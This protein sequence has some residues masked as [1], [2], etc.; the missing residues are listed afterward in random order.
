MKKSVFIILLITNISYL[1]AQNKF[2]INVGYTKN[3]SLLLDND[4]YPGM[5]LKDIRK[6]EREFEK[7]RP[8]HIRSPLHCIIVNFGMRSNNFE[9]G[10]YYGIGRTRI[11]DYGQ[12]VELETGKKV[13]APNNYYGG[14]GIGPEIQTFGIYSNFYVSALVNNEIFKRWINFY[15][16]AKVGG[17]Y[18]TKVDYSQTI[19]RFTMYDEL[20]AVHV[21]GEVPELK[22]Y[23]VSNIRSSP[24]GFGFNCYAGTGV[25]IFPFKKF[26]IFGEMGYDYFP[27]D[28]KVYMSKMA[29]RLGASIRI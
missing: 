21:V 2:V 8:R 5:S 7:A 15:V 6:M 11:Y 24:E 13:G 27:K 14:S 18:V 22:W 23:E 29:F 17:Y 16:S 9:N 19:V 28:G 20:P 10:C 1:F 12:L 3:S 4:R 25:A 26:G